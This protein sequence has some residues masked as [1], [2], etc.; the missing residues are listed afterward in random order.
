M[1]QFYLLR[2]KPAAFSEPF[3]GVNAFSVK[4]VN[5]NSS[6]DDILVRQLMILVI[7]R[8]ILNY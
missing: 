4:R 7:Y 8:T 1:L 5:F 2:S 6:P 3:S